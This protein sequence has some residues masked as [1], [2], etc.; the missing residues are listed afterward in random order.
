M[1]NTYVYM[2]L[3]MYVYVYM[4]IHVYTYCSIHYHMYIHMHDISYYIMSYL[5]PSASPPL[6]SIPE[7]HDETITQS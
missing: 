1:Y 5:P 4:I 3:C 6:Y 2:Y 7:G